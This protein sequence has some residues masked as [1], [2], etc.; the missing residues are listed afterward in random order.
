MAYKKFNKSGKKITQS[1]G[2]SFACICDDISIT[3]RGNPHHRKAVAIVQ[4]FTQLN[5]ET[6]GNEV[7]EHLRNIIRLDTRNP[8]GNETLAAEYLRSV[9]EA[10]DI[11]CTI[12]GPRPDRGTLVARL[13]GDGSEKPLLLMSHTDVVAVDPEKWTYGPFS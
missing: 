8:P 5:W 12:I 2:G 1:K 10:E 6:I 9:L 4:T 11:E 3:L 7:V 13:H